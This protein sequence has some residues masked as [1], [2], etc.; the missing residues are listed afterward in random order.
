MLARYLLSS[1]CS[2]LVAG[3]SCLRDSQEACSAEMPHQVLQAF[4][5]FVGSVDFICIEQFDSQYAVLISQ[6]ISICAPTAQCR[7]FHP[8]RG[9]DMAPKF[10]VFRDHFCCLSSAGQVITIPYGVA[11]AQGKLE[12]ICFS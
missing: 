7:W 2:T 9:K 10:G 5:L 6:P 12:H 4:Q 8:F 1:C 3:S 11:V